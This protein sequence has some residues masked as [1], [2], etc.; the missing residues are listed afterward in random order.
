MAPKTCCICRRS[1]KTNPSTYRKSGPYERDF[2]CCFGASAESRTGWLCPTC[3]SAVATEYRNN[4]DKTFEHLL[5]SKGKRGTHGQSKQ[6]IRRAL[7]PLSTNISHASTDSVGSSNSTC[8]TTP[9]PI[10]RTTNHDHQYFSFQSPVTTARTILPHEETPMI[11]RLNLIKPRTLNVNQLEARP[12]A[13]KRSLPVHVGSQ[14]PSALPCAPQIKKPKL[15]EQMV[16]SVTFLGKKLPQTVIDKILGFCTAEDIVNLSK[17]ENRSDQLYEINL[18]KRLNKCE[19]ERDEMQR[20]LDIPVNGPLT[21]PQKDLLSKLIR[22]RQSNL[23]SDGLLVVN[24]LRGKPTQ[25]LEVPATQQNSSAAASSTK[26]RRAK[27][28]ERLTNVLSKVSGE[29][30]SLTSPTNDADVHTQMVTL[31]KRNKDAY[32]KAAEDA[33]LKI[34]GRFRK[35]T[36]LALRSVMTQSMWRMIRRTL[37]TEIG[38]DVFMTEDT[39]KQE[40]QDIWNSGI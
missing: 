1:G 5:D 35:E 20:K 33:G 2:A 24:H 14:V 37:N 29:Q 32:A 15:K 31:I 6:G 21:Q 38:T 30:V 26:V 9:S 19:K 27:L 8:S 12:Q 23:D 4:R 28:I 34:V 17:C 36:V 39:L 3:R 13:Q 10:C 16:P 40:I 25:L 11:R 7:V 22:N 18:V